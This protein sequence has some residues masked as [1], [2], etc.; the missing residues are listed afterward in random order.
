MQPVIIY[1]P[2]IDWDYLH[3]RPQ[4]ILKALA[5]LDCICIFCNVNLYKRHP[6]GIIQLKE[7]LLLANGWDFTAAVK[8]ARSNYPGLPITAYFTYPAH[9]TPIQSAKPDLIIFDSVDEP[10]GEF[11]SW[12]PDYARALQQ[13]NV[14]TATACSLVS[15]AKSIV[16]KEVHLLPNGCDYEHFKTAQQRHDIHCLPFTGS[17]PI[18]GY[19]GAIAPWLDMQLVNSLARCLPDYEFVFIGSLLY[20]NTIA[21]PNRNMHYLHHQAYAELPRYLS[22]FNYSLIPFKLTEMTRGVNP[23]KFWEYLAGGIPIL[24]TP[25]PEIPP[26]YVTFITEAMLPGFSP[27]ADEKKRAAGIQF[28]CENSWTVRARKLRKI[29]VT[30]LE[31]G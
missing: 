20:Q 1:P 29:M 22:N 28:A 2:T 17:K 4:Q 25:L 10:A 16:T 27:A 6:G 24:S 15:R 5:G 23:V 11:I 21:F 18:I 30:E 14:V 9:I 7:N 8:W 12:L 3:Q 31:Y 19:I 13:A 26:E